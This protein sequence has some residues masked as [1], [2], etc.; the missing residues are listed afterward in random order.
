SPTSQNFDDSGGSDTVSVTA[1]VGCDWT[2]T[3]NDSWITI[4]SGSSGS[5]NGTVDY[6]VEACS[7]GTCPRSGTMTIAGELF[8]VTQE[9]DWDGDGVPDLEEQ[10]PNGDDPNYDGNADGTPD[11]EQDYV[12][13]MH[14]YSG[15]YYVTLE[16][17]STTRLEAVT[18]SGNPEPGSTPEGLSFP[19]DFFGFWVNNVGVG[20]STDVNLHLPTAIQIDTYYKFGPT[21]SNPNPQ[22]YEFLYD[23]QTETGAEINGNDVT[24]HFVDGERGDDDDPDDNEGEGVILDMGGPAL[25]DVG[26]PDVITDPASSVTKRSAH[27][28]GKVNPNGEETDYYFEYGTTSSYASVTAS[29]DAGSGT[30]DISVSIALQGLT[31]KTT[32]HFRIVATN[33]AGTSYG[34]DQTFTTDDNGGDGCFIGTVATGLWW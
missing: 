17:P 8:T 5:G 28:N 22:W 27:L 25:I 6:S 16:S 23:Q 11:W 19:Y 2:A 24:L 10:G 32:Y 20:G 4:T 14:T 33:R 21:S 31:K 12:A 15:Q 7:S 26:S 3:S 29:T 9:A 30:E 34:S 1:P 13:S 18:V